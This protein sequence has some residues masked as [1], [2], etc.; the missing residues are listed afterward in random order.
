MKILL[1]RLNRPEYI[2]Q[3]LQLYRRL[4]PHRHVN[5]KTLENVTLAWGAIL[6]VSPN[7]TIGSALLK[8]GLY[9][10]GVTET[11]WRL[12]DRGEICVDI[13]ANIGY[14]TSIMA[15]KSGATGVVYSFEPH[16]DLYVELNDNIANWHANLNWDHIKSYQIAVS[17]HSGEGLL[18]IPSF[19]S[20]NRGTASLVS[21]DQDNASTDDSITVK[22]STLEEV[23][24]GTNRIDVLKIDVEGH[25]LE[26]LS[27][28]A[29]Y[30]QKQQIRD[31]IFE[32]NDA[33][34]NKVTAY[35][36]RHG[37][38]LFKIQKKLLGPHLAHP[39]AKDTTSYWE[40][41]NYLATSEV[42]RAVQRMGKKGW[43]SLKGNMIPH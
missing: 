15:S 25:E 1:D 11:L 19:F 30:L 5:R 39:S 27:G 7:E 20:S 4:F 21:T 24:K 32:G 33:Y 3:P 10:L 31:V 43:A 23:M 13:G 9:D 36:E 29:A 18:H 6:Q 14:T 17:D 40:P 8:M 22:L 2:F 26:V 35:L 42:S 12:I 38:V 37:Y 41:T 34:P 28:A 16:P